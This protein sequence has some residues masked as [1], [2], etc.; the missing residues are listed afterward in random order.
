MKHRLNTDN[1]EFA[2]T[3][4]ELLVV[5]AITAIRAALLLTAISKPKQRADQIQCVNNV[6]QLRLAR[7]RY[8]FFLKTP[9]TPP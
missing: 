6:R 8:N 1:N 9:A 5:I 7:R 3:L 2:F 4:I